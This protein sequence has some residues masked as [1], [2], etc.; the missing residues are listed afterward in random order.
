MAGFDREAKPA[1][2]TGLLTRNESM[3][4]GPQH[5]HVTR[6]GI[7]TARRRTAADDDSPGD[8][9]VITRG[10]GKCGRRGTRRGHDGHEGKERSAHPGQG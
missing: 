9:G 2:T 1:I 3:V 8:R 6:L 5:H 4:C 7:T 10:G